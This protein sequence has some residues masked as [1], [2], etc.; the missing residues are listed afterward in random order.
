MAPLI[1]NLSA[2]TELEAVNAMLSAIGE[3]PLAAGTDLA[4]ATQ[5]DVQMALNILRNVTREVQSMGWKFNTEF[6]REIAPTAAYAWVD[7]AGVTTNLN[8]FAPPA[9]MISFSVTKLPEQQGTRLVDTEIRDSRKYVPGT[10][11]FY[12]R[13]KARD[14]FPLDL[15]PFLYI[16]PVW[17]IDFEDMPEVARRYCTARAAREFAESS[18]GSE[19]LSDF[20]KRN[21]AM[22]LRLLKREQGEE[23][24][25][26]M[27][28]NA[29]VSRARGRR[30]GGASGVSDPRKNR[31]TV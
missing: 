21:E 19:T 16:N 27:L 4:T 9:G 3:A 30:P 14:G 1:V 12:D 11:V 28:Y 2:T 20:S 10:R 7:S 29:D 24:D 18:V 26:N 25:Y 5:A 13:S 31:N 6:G 8:I 22:A 17:F 15:H 23:D